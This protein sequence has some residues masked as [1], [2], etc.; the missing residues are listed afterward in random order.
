MWTLRVKARQL[1]IV[2]EGA[3]LMALICGID[4]TSRQRNVRPS[5]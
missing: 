5:C 4:P 2:M 1:W 3:M